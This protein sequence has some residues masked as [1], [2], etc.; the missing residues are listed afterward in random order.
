[1]KEDCKNSYPC[2][3]VSL[4]KFSF[5]KTKSLRSRRVA[6]MAQWW[7]RS[8]TTN[9]ARVRFPDGRLHMWVEFV[10]GSLICSER[11]FSGYS[12][13]PFSLKTDVSKFRF[14][15]GTHGHFWTSS[16]ELLS[17]PWVNKLH[18]FFMWLRMRAAYKWEVFFKLTL[19]VIFC[20]QVK[21][22]CR[23]QY[24]HDRACAAAGQKEATKV[25]S[26]QKARW[27]WGRT[28]PK[29]RFSNSGGWS[30]SNGT[31]S[32]IQTILSVMREH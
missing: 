16:F 27:N 5:F 2:L 31:A 18:Y 13:L 23:K 30:R 21:L 22:D 29:S 4:F 17:A 10:V 26:E 9:M 32:A 25:Q 3:T 14:H 28:Q 19:Y 20:C 1:M 12:G 8:P 24:R 11:F 6:G 15:P 7:E